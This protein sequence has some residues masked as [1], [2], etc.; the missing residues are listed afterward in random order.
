MKQPNDRSYYTARAVA[1]R[2][3]ALRAAD[4]MTAAIHTRLAVRYDALAAQ[5]PGTRELT[6]EDVIQA[7]DA[8]ELQ[9]K[10]DREYELVRKPLRLP[11]VTL[12]C[13]HK[14]GVCVQGRLLCVCV[15][16]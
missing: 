14:C 7:P 9:K 11:S 5:P 3:L 1:S 2:T 8:K 4:A 15:G 12:Y 6:L 16:L 10:Q 13:C